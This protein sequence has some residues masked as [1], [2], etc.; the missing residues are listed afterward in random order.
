MDS[1]T[2]SGHEPLQS[3]I[4][5]LFHR[6]LGDHVLKVTAPQDGGAWIPECHREGKAQ[7]S[8]P[9]PNQTVK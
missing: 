2:T 3:S 1:T 6:D 5:C 8:P 9:N 7:E 4:L